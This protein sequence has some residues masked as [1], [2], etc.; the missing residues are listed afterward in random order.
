V[1]AV[2][3]LPLGVYSLSRDN[4]AAISWGVWL[5]IGV[6]IILPTVGAYYLNAWALTQVSPSTVA[7]YIYLQPLVAFG[8]APLL[9]GERWNSRTAVATLLIFAGVGLVVSRGRSRAVREIS[10]HPDAL[11]H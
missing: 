9:L 5:M 1:S 2:L 6:I 8:F 11:A 10:E 4:L 7:I 3:T